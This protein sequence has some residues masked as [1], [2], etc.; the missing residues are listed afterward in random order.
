MQLSAAALV[1]PWREAVVAHR[2]FLHAHPELSFR[3][4]ETAAY[5]RRELAR[6]GMECTAVPGGNSLVG[7]LRGKAPG[8]TVAFRADIDALPIQ[9]RNDW[10]YR[11]QNDGVM[12]A[13]GHD[14]HTAALLGLAELFAKNTA[15][16]RGEV[17]F[18][19]QQAEEVP[20]GGGEALVHSGVLEGVDAVF[21]AHIWSPLEVGTIGCKEGAIMACA[22]KF[23]IAVKGQGGHGSE[24][25]NTDDVLL[26]GAS[27]VQQLQSIVSRKI[28]PRVPAVLSVCQFHAGSAFNIIPDRCELGG[29]VRTCD[30]TVRDQIP[31]LIRAAAESIVGAVPGA[32]CQ[33]EYTKG[34]PMVVNDGHLTDL[35]AKAVRT[36]TA[37]A[38]REVPAVMGGDDFAYYRQAAPSVYFFVGG[39]N[40]QKAIV[41]P[42]H[43]PR[44][45]F[46]EDALHI[47]ME[48][49]LASYL[50]LCGE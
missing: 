47:L 38:Y 14:G 19:F 49:F 2:R 15:L 30:E 18:V 13:C 1:A 27:I 23:T 3:E 4:R 34:Y 45:D 44:F 10:E 31:R 36:D 29:T 39:G 42:H 12:H 6:C 40:S 41:Q 8:R 32:G 21:G 43:H 50:R 24:P 20:P 25:Q 48:V 22:D 9:E 16:I 28:D 26:L 11:S 37:H 17:R 7:R 46:D 5:I 33:V 35:V